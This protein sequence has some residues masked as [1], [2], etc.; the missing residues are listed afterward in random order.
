[1]FASSLT[2]LIIT[3]LL[4]ATL[5]A[6]EPNT[7]TPAEIA[8]GWILLF[9]GNTT[10]G[11]EP[12][13]AADWKVAGGIIS[14]TSGPPGLLCTTSEFGDYVLKVDFRAPEDT[15]SGVFL[16][17]PLKPTDAGVDCYEL[18]I[19]PE[20]LSPF[21]T[22]SFVKRQKASPVTPSDDWRSYEVTA[23]GGHFVVKLDG[24][25]VLD[26]TDPK[27]VPRG[28]IGLQQNAGKAEFR[29]IR[30]KPL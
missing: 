9:D 27:P 16:R 14:V 17:T 22:G 21:P 10:V 13:S 11:W 20:K 1:M 28:R 26:Y 8:D 12:S 2:P 3:C 29:N 25:T 23:Q 30:L 7:L 24:Q 18:Q 19:A 5:S 15:N 4:T 6:A